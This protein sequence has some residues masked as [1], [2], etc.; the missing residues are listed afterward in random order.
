MV[1]PTLHSKKRILPLITE[2]L[3][4][5]TVHGLRY[6]AECRHIIEKLFWLVLIGGSFG[7]AWYIIEIFFIEAN[8]DPILT[9]IESI[10]VR[11]VPFPAVT[12]RHSLTFVHNKTLKN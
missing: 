10:P 5:S 2:Y 3:E 12:I 4:T 7:Y 9:T 8:N 1:K 6:L 11:D